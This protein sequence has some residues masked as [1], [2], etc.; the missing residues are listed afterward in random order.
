MVLAA[1]LGSSKGHGNV[2]RGLMGTPHSPLFEGR[3]GRM[4]R[5]LPGAAFADQE[6]VALATAM[7]AEAEDEVTSENEIDD[8]EN[9]GIPAGY[10]YL[11]QF[12]DHDI[13]FDPLSSL[14]Q[15]NDPDGLVDFRTP[16]LDMDCLYGRGP[17]DQP[18]LFDPTGRKF[19]QSDRVLTGGDPEKPF[20]PDLARFKGRALIGDKR[21]D[22]NVI[23]SQLQGF[24]QRFH[25]YIAWT[26]PDAS[27]AEIQRTVRWHFQWIVLFDFLPRII[28]RD[29]VA[30][31]LPHVQ[32]GRSIYAD[33]PQLRFF[34]WHNEP[35]MP[36]EFSGAAY[37]FGH[38]MVRP[39]Y[40]LSQKD[41]PAHGEVPGGLEG[42]KAIFAA[43][44]LDGLNGFREFP[45]DWGID[46]RLYFD[47][48]NHRLA[49]KSLGKKRVQPS[50]K[51]DAS[52]VSPLGALPEFS[53]PGS[54][55]PQTGAINV[56]A[57]RNL[58][59]GMRL[60]LPSG[61]DAA[62]F[63]DL[64]PLKD[65]ELLVGK[66]NVDGLKENKPIAAFG[67]SFVDNAPLWA[68]VLAEAGHQWAVESNG[69]S[70]DEAKNTTPARLG[71]V[72]SRIVGEVLIGLVLGSKQSFLA[73]NPSWRPKFGHTKADSVFDRFTM[74]DLVDLLV[75]K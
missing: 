42:R 19:L 65:D 55:T 60:G 24:F 51:L 4:F 25:N 36:V 8:E 39:V 50:Y 10:T 66:A 28:G 13:T 29:R 14:A 20:E 72:G 64:V 73:L 30:Q 69:K 53:I 61:Q 58:M 32:S 54:N 68:Y 26:E 44:P 33:K 56:L 57:L 74:G 38:S 16:A 46:W 49:P 67:K 47:T 15:Q 52:L 71:E 37:R 45:G 12:I 5:A 63:M 35:F 43:D 6:L 17:E 40:R 34:H 9:F 23:V 31:I 75:P 21:N 62:R 7:T 70:G 48:R 18:Y 2:E 11:G 3:F 27:F 22:E 1:R 59:R 41:L